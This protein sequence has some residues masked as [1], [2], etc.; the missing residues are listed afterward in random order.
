MSVFA[1]LLN[2]FI[3]SMTSLLFGLVIVFLY[4][5]AGQQKWIAIE[6]KKNRDATFRNFISLLMYGIIIGFVSSAIIIFLGIA[7]SFQTA[8][9]LYIPVLVLLFFQWNNIL[10]SILV[11]IISL[12]AT[13]FNINLS[14]PAL[15]AFTGILYFST[16]LLTILDGDRDRISVITKSVN[17]KSKH[18]GSIYLDRIWALPLIVLITPDEFIK[19]SFLFSMPEW[20]PLFNSNNSTN[21]FV[22]LPIIAVLGYHKLVRGTNTSKQIKINGLSYIFLGIFCFALGIISSHIIYFVYLSAI[23]LPIIHLLI[24]KLEYKFINNYDEYFKAPWRGLKI[25]DTYEN[26]IA[27]N[28]GVQ[29]GDILVRIN[30]QDINSLKMFSY[31][32]ESAP[33]T[34]E[35]HVIRNDIELVFKYNGERNIKN[36]GFI[37]VPR[38]TYKYFIIPTKHN[39]IKSE[40]NKFI[41]KK[42]KHK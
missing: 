8:V 6:W 31:Y 39:F 4:I 25:I 34:L 5:H 23:L 40:F 20:W 16:G 42:N 17:E 29:Q 18:I 7:I 35:F 30:D 19:S 26:S 13:I 27:Q 33:T 15:I 12:V 2:G 3:K 32:M 38:N 9:V 36:V 21:Y 10:L 22:M 14:V 28:L 37:F 41:N 24:Y 11:S 1:V